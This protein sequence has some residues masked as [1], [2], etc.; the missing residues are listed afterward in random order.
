MRPGTLIPPGVRCTL[1]SSLEAD[2]K[3]HSVSVQILNERS[4]GAAARI[5]F[6]FPD[7]S[8]P[9]YQLLPV[10]LCLRLH[11]SRA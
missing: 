2:E 1:F 11:G 10:A 5:L 4:N 9:V 7:V 6:A 8:K 3:I